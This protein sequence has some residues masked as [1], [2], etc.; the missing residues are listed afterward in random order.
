M[1]TF[2]AATGTRGTGRAAGTSDNSI[3][4]GITVSDDVSGGGTND[5]N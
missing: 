4:L 1:L 2:P 3:K 5:F